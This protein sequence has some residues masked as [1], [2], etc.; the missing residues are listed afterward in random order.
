MDSTQG[1][2][3]R[4]F[5]RGLTPLA[6]AAALAALAHF[7]VLGS[8]HGF[9]IDTAGLFRDE[10]VI[11]WRLYSVGAVIFYVVGG[12][13]GDFGGHRRNLIIGPAITAGA[14][15]LM[16]F[17]P[18]SDDAG[19]A[20]FVLA[21][22]SGF[23]CGRALSGTAGAALAAHL[24]EE[25]PRCRVPLVG[26]FTTLHVAVNAAVLL[27]APFASE[28]LE[29]V[30]GDAFGLGRIESARLLLFL[31][32]QPAL[33]AMIAAMIGKR[34]FAAAELAARAKAAAADAAPLDDGAVTYRRSALGLL[35]AAVALGL[36]AYDA[37]MTAAFDLAARLG[38]AGGEAG[39]VQAVNGSIVVFLA[40]IAVIAYG[41]MRRGSGRVPTAGV[42]VIGAALV[43]T[44][45][46]ILLATAAGMPDAPSDFA[47]PWLEDAPSPAWPIAAMILVSLGE[48]LLVPVAVSLFASLAPRRLRGLF[49][50]IALG[51]SGATA[52]VARLAGDAFEEIPP[53][54]ATALAL[55]AAVG[56]AALFAVVGTVFRKRAAA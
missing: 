17:T 16:M 5:P 38:D 41:R 8:L 1:T 34:A 45:L 9:L 48:I 47:P 6:I 46:T 18:E 2:A 53:G 40:P 14:L 28:S 32:A 55:A 44:A 10:G 19:A 52:L 11:V 12:L 54:A 21:G 7:M 50:G 30:L 36:T 27:L 23:A 26:A 13:W 22:L 43:A 51:L 42:A 15:L 31:S 29:P 49:V 3:A 37:A 20:L 39:A 24:Y 4:L 25:E 33:G 35:V 56:C